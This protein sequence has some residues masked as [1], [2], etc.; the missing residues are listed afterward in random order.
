MQELLQLENCDETNTNIEVIN[1]VLRVSH[2]NDDAY[3]KQRSIE[4]LINKKNKIYI[5]L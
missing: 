3:L 4:E 2:K 5:Y 1:N